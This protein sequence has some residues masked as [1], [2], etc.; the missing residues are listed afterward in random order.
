VPLPGADLAVLD[1]E[2]TLVVHGDDVLQ[3]VRLLVRLRGEAVRGGR[4]E[5]LVDADPAV[6]SSVMPIRSGRCRRCR[7]R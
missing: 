5:Q 3:L 2:A 6:R 4:R 1:G 7:D